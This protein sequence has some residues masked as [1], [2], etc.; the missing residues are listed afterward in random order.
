M[1]VMTEGNNKE[2]NLLKLIPE[3][4]IDYEEGEDDMVTLLAPRFRSRFLPKFM[5]SRLKRKKFRVAL[6]EIGSFVWLRCDGTRTAGQIADEMAARFGEEAEPVTERLGI[7]FG[8]LEKL[9]YI[10]FTNIEEC[11]E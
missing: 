11:A 8:Q 3:R 5:K 10:R 1:N 6:D 2:I 9:E 7:F 4:T